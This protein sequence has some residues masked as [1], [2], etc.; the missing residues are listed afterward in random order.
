MTQSDGGSTD[1]R[2]GQEAELGSLGCA[3][4]RLSD[5]GKAA[6]QLRGTLEI[7]MISFWRRKKEE[8][9]FKP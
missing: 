8:E 9:H 7:F 2:G 6:C 4:C 1:S 3:W 5:P